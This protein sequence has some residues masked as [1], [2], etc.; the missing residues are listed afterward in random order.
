MIAKP[1]CTLFSICLIGGGFIISKNLKNINAISKFCG[2]KGIKITAVRHPAN[3]SITIQEGSLV[4]VF[5]T[6]LSELI[7]PKINPKINIKKSIVFDGLK[8]KRITI[9]K[10]DATVPGAKGK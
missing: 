9:A 4:F 8:R 3:S 7:T 10:A 2:V 5:F 6:I 1:P